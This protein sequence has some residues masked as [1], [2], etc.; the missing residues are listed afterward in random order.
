MVFILSFKITFLGYSV[1]SALILNLTSSISS[2]QA[3]NTKTASVFSD[4]LISGDGSSDLTF[5]ADCNG[6]ESGIGLT[7]EN[8]HDAV[9]HGIPDVTKRA[10]INYGDRNFGNFDVNLPQR[11]ISGK[12]AFLRLRVYNINHSPFRRWT[13]PR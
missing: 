1:A 13:L 7:K 3:L 8:C 12:E 6:A 5:E 10:V 9:H 2:Q 4:Y 11:Y